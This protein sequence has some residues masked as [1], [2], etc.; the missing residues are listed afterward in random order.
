MRLLVD[1]HTVIWAVDDPSKLSRQAVTALQDPGNDLLLS[2]G[3]RV[4]SYDGQNWVFDSMHDGG[5]VS[6]FRLRRVDRDTFQ[7]YAFLNGSRSPT[8]RWTRVR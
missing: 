6:R 5:L 1:A 3:L 4:I 7:G 2:R 8:N